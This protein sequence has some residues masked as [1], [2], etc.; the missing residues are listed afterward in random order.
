MSLTIFSLPRPFIGEFDVIQHNAIISWRLGQPNAEIILFGNEKGTRQMARK[1]NARH[2]PNIGTNK[3]GTPYVNQI[4][5]RAQKISRFNILCYVNAD[6]IFIG[7]IESA[8]QQI[9]KKFKQFVLVIRRYDLKLEQRQD[10][11][12]NWEEMIRKKLVEHGRK[13]Q[14]GAVDAFIFTRGAYPRNDFPAFLLGRQL[15]DGWLVWKAMEGHFPTIEIT[16]AVTL[17]HQDHTRTE[18]YLDP[19]QLLQEKSINRNLFEG[20][21]RN[22]NQTLWI[23]THEG[24]RQR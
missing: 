5:T 14:P 24:L 11:N 8:I 9:Q 23:L 4:F 1:V 20:H 22:I 12:G 16:S 15:W 19:K 17:I 3:F 10:F 13:H 18:D 21:K 7:N 2:Y 6:I